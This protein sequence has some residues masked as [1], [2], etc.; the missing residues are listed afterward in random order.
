MLKH[1]KYNFLF[2]SI[3]RLTNCNRCNMIFIWTNHVTP[4]IKGKK[5]SEQSVFFFFLNK[6]KIEEALYSLSFRYN[7][8][9]VGI[10]TLATFIT[11]IREHKKCPYAIVS[12][13]PCYSCLAGKGKLWGLNYEASN[14]DV[15]L[16]WW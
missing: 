8:T 2:H 14:L 16:L 11:F 3:L 1:K 5:K 10:W 6:V 4:V 9:L 12:R 15:D 13:G 7:N